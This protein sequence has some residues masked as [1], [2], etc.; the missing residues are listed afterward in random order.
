MEHPSDLSTSLFRQLQQRH[1]V[2]TLEPTHHTEP[3][4]AF[5]WP[6]QLRQQRLGRIRVRVRIRVTRSEGGSSASCY[7]LNCGAVCALVGVKVL[8]EPGVGCG[9]DRQCL[10]P[11][12]VDRSHNNEPNEPN[13]PQMERQAKCLRWSLSHDHA[14]P[15]RYGLFEFVEIETV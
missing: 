13:R 7:G 8:S 11:L 5:L 2:G 1:R 12:E 14:P 9:A 4:L 3:A 15:R 6:R 10:R